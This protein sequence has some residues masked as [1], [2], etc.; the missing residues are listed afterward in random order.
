[1]IF[2]SFLLARTFVPR[3]FRKHS[4]QAETSFPSEV[5]KNSCQTTSKTSPLTTR[6]I[7]P[8]G[9]DQEVT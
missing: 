4:L 6:R 1:M 7:D 8:L 2:G 3:S 9:I 5:A